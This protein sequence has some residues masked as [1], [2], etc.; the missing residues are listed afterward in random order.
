MQAILWENNGTYTYL[1]P[2]QYTNTF[3]RAIND[4]GQI[5]GTGEAT[6]K[7]GLFWQDLIA[8]PKE[9]PAPSNWREIV[10]LAINNSGSVVGYGRGYF[11]WGHAFLYSN[12][13]FTDLHDSALWEN[14][15]ASDINEKG[16]V[17][18]EAYGYDGSSHKLIWE[19]GIFEDIITPA[20]YRIFD[21]SEINDLGHVVGSGGHL[22][23]GQRYAFL[24]KPALKLITIELKPGSDT[25][26]FNQN[27]R[28]VIPVA[29]L[30]S[31]DLD[32][33]EINVESLALQ[34][35]TVKMVGKSNKYLAHIE[36]VNG[37]EYADLVVQFQDSD[38]WIS[39]GNGTTTLTG[40]LSDGTQIQGSD[41]ICIVP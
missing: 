29:I 10:P 25:N 35:L 30:G 13:E 20:D 3:A 37:D 32:V 21:L 28:G 8:S 7:S 38:G 16:Q 33:S 36:N 4:S 22:G 31:A 41:S 9:I 40:Q 18:V 14:T 11:F 2:G 24:A 15:F 12:D 23:T 19:N 1:T 17:L 39:P 26:C 27:E 34:G 5:V 6:R